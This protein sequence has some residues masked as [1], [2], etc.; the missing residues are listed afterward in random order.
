MNTAT[1]TDVWWLKSF[2]TKWGILRACRHNVLLEGPVA[3][4][5]AGLRLLQPQI[6]EPIVWNG[7]QTPLDL[8]SGEIGRLILRNV[9]GLSGEDQTRLLTWLG[10][11]GS[12]TQIVS[13]TEHPLFVL[14][15]RGLFDETLYYRLNVMLLRVGSKDKAGLATDNAEPL[16]IDPPIALTAP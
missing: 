5:N 3:A 1:V 7:P 11:L 8:P 16:H 13:T 12:R 9:A 15:A 6:R 2:Q 4:T 14:V 10:G